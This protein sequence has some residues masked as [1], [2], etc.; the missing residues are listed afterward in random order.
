MLVTAVVTKEE[1][2][3]WQWLCSY[4]TVCVYHEEVC[5]CIIYQYADRKL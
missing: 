5:V 1:G 3:C 2:E 4:S